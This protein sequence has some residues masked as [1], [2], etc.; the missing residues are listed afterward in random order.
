[1]ARQSTYGVITPV[2]T[3][4][5][6]ATDNPSGTPVHGNIL[7]S[8][9]R[10][11]I[12]TNLTPAANARLG[13][14]V[15]VTTSGAY[16]WAVGTNPVIHVTLGGNHAINPASALTEDLSFTLILDWDGNTADFSHANWQWIGGA[17]TPPGSGKLTVIQGVV[18]G[19]KAL[20][21]WVN[22]DTTT[23]S[24]ITT[25]DC[26][27]GDDVA[28]TT[29]EDTIIFAS[30]GGYLTI[31]GDSGTKTVT[32]AIDPSYIAFSNVASAVNQVTVTNAATGNGPSLSATG[33]DTDIDLSLAPKGDGNLILDGLSWPITDGTNGQ[34]L[35]TN[36]AGV[37]SWGSGGSGPSQLVAVDAN[38]LHVRNSTTDQE[39][40]IMQTYTDASNYA[41]LSINYASGIMFVEST[42]AGTPAYNH[43]YLRVADTSKTIQ[44]Q[45]GSTRLSIN[46]T[47][48]T[49]YGDVLASGTRN[50]GST[51]TRFAVGHIGKLNMAKVSAAN[52]P[53]TTEL[54]TDGDVAV[55]HNTSSGARFLAWNDGGTIYTVA[56]T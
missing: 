32:F 38:T 17:P 39:L 28:A 3:D 9:L 1:M 2:L 26:P 33:T 51:G 19:G 20:A 27:A 42:R 7:V 56:L 52:D 31:T 8:A 49:F 30:G 48:S 23:S 24:A 6:S 41:G 11:V 21:G 34:V 45:I 35:T 47:G 37:L 50:I 12:E 46:S 53:T 40:I 44:F 43:L 13:T 14:A 25:V 22:E 36:G 18:K 16:N 55:Y 4:Y 5:V 15:D 54:P 29:L 10:D